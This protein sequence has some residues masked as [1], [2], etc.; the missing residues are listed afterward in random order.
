[1]SSLPRVAATIALLMAGAANAQAPRVAADV[2]PVH[3]LVARVMDGVGSPALIVPPGASP[4]DHALRPSEAA[5]VQDASLIFW[6]GPALTP[7]L[8]DALGTL[9]PEADAVALLDLP[10][11]R[12]L[13]F[14]EGALFEAHDHGDGHD[15]DHG[16]DHE[17]DHGH[18]H[19]GDHAAT[20]GHGHHEGAADPHAWLSPGNAAAWLDAIAARLGEADPANAADYRANAAA[21]RNELAALSAEIDAMVAPVRDGRFVVFHDAYQYFEDAFGLEASG[22]ISLGDASAPSPGRIA[23]IRDRIADEQVGCVLA[24]PQFDQGL[25]ATVMDGTAA[26]TGVLDPLGAALEPG[27]D[28]YPAMMRGLAQALA[29]CL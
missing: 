16:H 9:A 23:E 15:H 6:I 12:V 27:P 18:D 21:G 3:S 5:A 29:D 20:G 25:V 4:H 24:E 1:M 8:A 17:H 13:P 11:T 14:R 10:A 28:L 22:A 26:R 19:D 2:A 7:Q